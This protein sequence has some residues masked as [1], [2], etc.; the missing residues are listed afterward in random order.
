MGQV[1]SDWFL[2]AGKAVRSIGGSV[3]FLRVF[4]NIA[5]SLY[6][7]R[8]GLARHWPGKQLLTTR[9][10]PSSTKRKLGGAYFVWRSS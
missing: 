8:S 10:T 3:K 5:T 7:A 1:N 2:G 9:V 6:S 4:Q